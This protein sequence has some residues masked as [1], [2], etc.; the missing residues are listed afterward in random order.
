MAICSKC[1]K[2]I[3]NIYKLDGKV[4]G[5]N[6]YKI[7]LAEKYKNYID[8]KNLKYSLVAVATVETYKNHKEASKW[9][10]DFKQSILKQFSEC[11]KLTYKQLSCIVKRLSAEEKLNNDLLICSLFKDNN[12]KEE[13][14]KQCKDISYYFNKSDI[15]KKYKD[16]E[17]FKQCIKDSYKRH[18]NIYAEL[19]DNEEY[20][21][22]VSD[23]KLN[24]FIEEA[25]E[26]ADIKIL[27]IIRL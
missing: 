21:Y 4:Y 15:I 22:I 14:L 5:Y 6:C 1:G 27:E 18:M 13:Y 7:A 24:Y 2:E 3:K 10:I 11:Q 8:T 20:W 19:D 16:D 9:G 25:E 23:K 12:L 26:D 17:L